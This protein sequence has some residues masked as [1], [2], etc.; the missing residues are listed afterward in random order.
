MV[1]VED[2]VLVDRSKGGFRK[3]RPVDDAVENVD[4]RRRSF[5]HGEAAEYRDRMRELDPVILSPDQLGDIRGSRRATDNVRIQADEP[6]VLEEPLVVMQLLAR[7]L[8]E[9]RNQPGR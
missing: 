1:W 8:F 7:V 4:I 2:R 3:A 9:I 6:H 5:E